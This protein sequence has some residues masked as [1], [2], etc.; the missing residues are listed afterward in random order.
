MN[1]KILED[2]CTPSDS[3]ME[4][5]TQMVAES[6]DVI[7]Q[8]WKSAQRVTGQN[9]F[10][11]IVENGLRDVSVMIMPRETGITFLNEQGYDTSNP[12]LSRIVEPATGLTQDSQALW[13]VVRN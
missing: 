13:V 3:F 6:K 10:L 2:D 5:A 4:K 7:L 11:A 1:D 8:A 9:D 12:V